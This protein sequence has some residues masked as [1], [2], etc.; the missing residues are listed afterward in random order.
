MITN[1]FIDKF[2]YQCFNTLFGV[3]SIKKVQKIENL[4]SLNFRCFSAKNILTLEFYHL[5]ARSQQSV[6][7]RS[8]Y[9][10]MARASL[11]D[12]LAF[13]HQFTGVNLRFQGAFYFSVDQLIFRGL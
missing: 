1:N 2:C 10:V 13:L 5:L 11:S 8:Q 6:V 7:T 9:V 4:V 12:I 3:D